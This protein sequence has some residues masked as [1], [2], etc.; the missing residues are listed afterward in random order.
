MNL[1]LQLKKQISDYSKM[2]L[3]TAEETDFDLKYERKHYV[4]PSSG[5]MLTNDRLSVVKAFGR[6]LRP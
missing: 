3:R 6:F 5:H 4:S 2:F 1:K